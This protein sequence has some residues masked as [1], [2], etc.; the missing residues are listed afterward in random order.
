M[1]VRGYFIQYRFILPDSI[2]H[3]SYTYQKLFRAIYGYTQAVHKGSGKNYQYHRQGI[4]SNYPFIR[5]GKNCVIIP[6]V[7][8]QPLQEFFKTGHNPTHNWETKGEWKC[9]YFL[10]EKDLTE[11]EVIK[12]LNNLISRKFIEGVEGLALLQNEMKRAL[13]TQL[14]Q[15]YVTRLVNEAQKIVDL[16][17]FKQVYSQSPELN[18]FYENYK[19]LKGIQ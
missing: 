6:S 19:K 7:A 16:E 18:D 1:S 3:S 2:K 17:W 10:N 15:N 4:L 8:F 9:T 14:D 5:P 11:A 13:S 12:S